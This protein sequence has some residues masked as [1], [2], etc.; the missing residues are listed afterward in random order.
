MIEPIF[1]GRLGNV[2]FQIAAAYAYSLK[3]GM[4]YNVP[5]WGN[6]LSGA[7]DETDKHQRNGRLESDI[8][9]KYLSWFPNVKRDNPLTGEYFL[10]QE[11]GRHEYNEI[12]YHQNIKID[13]FFQSEKYFS[14]YR[15]EIVELF[16]LP[17]E[18]KSGVVSIHVRRGD[19]V[20]YHTSF[21]PVERTYLKPAITGFVK[22]NIKKFLVF[23]DDIEW[24]KYNLTSSHYPDCS[25]EFSEG[26]NEYEDLVL[27]SQCEHNIIANSSFSWWGAWL[28]RNPNK[29]VVSPS[30][31]NWFGSRVKLERKD[32]IPQGWIQ[33]RY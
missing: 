26:R 28:N 27:M 4:D 31:E 14:D 24:C 23:S 6:G 2:M 1:T 15:N 11:N 3:H 17:Y 9:L 8:M 12:P 30:A 16:N 18:L 7:N 21:P 22:M 33:V 13:G 19:Y 32:I 29:I 25:F 5:V 20:K 10:Y